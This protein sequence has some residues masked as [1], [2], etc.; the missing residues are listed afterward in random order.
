MSVKQC[1]RNWFVEIVT[2][3]FIIIHGYSSSKIFTLLMLRPCLENTIY[4]VRK[5][6]R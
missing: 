2:I 1:R 6:E 5:R 3:D 4:R